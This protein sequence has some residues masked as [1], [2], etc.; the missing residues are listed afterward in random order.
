M[1]F[2][3]PVGHEVKYRMASDEGEG[4]QCNSRLV[5]CACMWLVAKILIPLSS[6]YAAESYQF[7]AEVDHVVVDVRVQERQTGRPVFGLTC[8]DF[9]VTVDGGHRR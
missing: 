4:L 3:T 7:K 6:A 9:V 1:L 2:A 5:I 8:D